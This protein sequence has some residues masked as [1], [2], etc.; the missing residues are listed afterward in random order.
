MKNCTRWQVDELSA[1]MKWLISM[2]NIREEAENERPPSL[3]MRRFF[4][5]HFW[6]TRTKCTSVS[7][8]ALYEGRREQQ[9]HIILPAMGWITWQSYAVQL[10][11]E[12]HNRKAKQDCL[13]GI[14]THLSIYDEPNEEAAQGEKYI[15]CLWV[16]RFK[17]CT[18]TKEI[19]ATSPRS[20]DK[21]SFIG[22]TPN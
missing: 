8:L 9:I 18:M 12:T 4:N 19:I 10:I 11:L 20:Q 16:S 13:V 21:A 3:L 15:D 1:L 17:Y 14:H 7:I 22:D 5:L 6:T 2:N